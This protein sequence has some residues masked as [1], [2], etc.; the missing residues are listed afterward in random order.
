MLKNK[1]IGKNF[2]TKFL[3]GVTLSVLTVLILRSGFVSTTSSASASGAA[4]R[5]SSQPGQGCDMEPTGVDTSDY[6]LNFEVPP[7]L[8]PD[9][10]FDGKPA[11]LE[12]HRVRPVYAHGKC[13]GVPNRAIVLIHG[14]TIPGPVLFDMRHPTA[15]DPDGGKLSLQESLAM[16]GIDTF[17]PSLLGYGRS[18]RFDK[19]LDDPCNASL[20]PYNADGSCSFVKG[21][22]RSW[23]QRIFPLNQQ[24]NAI[25]INPLDG[26]MC[27]HSSG[28]RFANMD[29]WA[30]DVKQVID[31]AIARAH[32]DNNKI[33]LVGNS[34][35]GVSVARA[36]Y[37]LADQ[38]GN[39]VQR[40]VF[41]SSFFDRLPGP[42]PGVEIDATLPTEERDLSQAALSTS[43]P[44]ALFGRPGGGGSQ[45]EDAA[46]AGRVI[47]G[48]ADDV[49]EQLMERDA[50]GRE[51]GGNDPRNPAGLL[52]APTFSNHGWNP[53]VASTF[54]I[55][56][57]V[58]HG[59]NDEIVPLSNSDHIYEALTL[60]TNKA[61]VQVK[62]ASHAI[63]EN[64]CSGAR[65]DDGDPNTMPYGGNSQTW[66]G[67]YSTVA[68]AL[69]E[70]VK[71]GTFNGSGSGRFV[72]NESGVVSN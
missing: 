59:F 7:G 68:A 57:L 48:L 62:C 5:P 50:L 63:L 17:A 19:G 33:V 43:F 55:P 25:I 42:Q 61:L 34:L 14:R 71:H 13:Q 54:T 45:E 29:V 70:W 49:W 37:K 46:C 30:R 36:L 6:W 39:K 26:R 8:M 23:L 22:D 64:G 38:A 16:A 27:K 1:K 58:L 72:I 60:V 12:V 18:T 65:C 32:P 41:L 3:L 67:P 2:I 51:W 9:K 56:T 24:S 15:E 44:M 52:R 20:P 53:A 40:V 66:A 35:G 69:I 11:K 47:P 21:C 4:S 10:H 31:D 28:Y